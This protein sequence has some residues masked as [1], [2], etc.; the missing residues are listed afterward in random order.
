MSAGEERLADMLQAVWK[1][2]PSEFGRKV[3]NLLDDLYEGLYHIPTAAIRKAEWEHNHR[4]TLTVKDTNY[5]TAD[6]DRLT[7]LVFLAH[8]Y[9]VR[10]A[11]RGAA[12]GYIRLVFEEV[13]RHNF[14]IQRHPTLEEAVQKFEANNVE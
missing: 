14:L 5:A 11:I 9:G 4:I 2:T 3:A 13:N 10:V 12:S 7:K 6:V 1:R 8:R